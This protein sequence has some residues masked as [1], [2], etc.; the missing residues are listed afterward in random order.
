M[1]IKK[2]NLI[3]YI[4]IS[5]RLLLLINLNNNSSIKLFK[6]TKLLNNYIDI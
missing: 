4:I 5:K 6:I 3:N 1:L 2:L